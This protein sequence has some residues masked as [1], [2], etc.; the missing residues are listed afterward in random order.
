MA[1]AGVVEQADVG[2]DHRVDAEICGAV[3]GT[4]PVSLAPR[5]R[6]G[7]DRH[8][9]VLAARMGVVDALD[10]RLLIKIEA[11]EVARVGVVL[12]AEVH[13]VGPVI[14]RSLE[15]RQT[16]GGTNEFG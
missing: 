15:R 5:L 4:V 9:H 1:L 10:H 2:E 13:G 3:D 11:G 14:D 7:V 8:Q 16:A 12:I 6:E